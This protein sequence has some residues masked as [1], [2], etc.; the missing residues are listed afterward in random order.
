MFNTI[1]CICLFLLSI[2]N[3]IEFMNED[4]PHWMRSGELFCF[5]ALFVLFMER[6][7]GL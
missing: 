4:H 3:L 1:Y 6:V 7:K 2:T 5:V